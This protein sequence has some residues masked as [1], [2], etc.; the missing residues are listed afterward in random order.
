[1]LLALFKCVRMN[2]LS[3]NVWIS[4]CLA[5]SAN[6]S[7][8]PASIDPSSDTSKYSVIGPWSISAGFPQ[9]GSVW[10]SP[11]LG[12]RN[13]I[14]N[15]EFVSVGLNLASDKISKSESA[16]VFAKWSHMLSPGWGKSFPYA[17]V[18]SGYL[19]QKAN[20][21]A[22]NESSAN[23]A[24]GLGVE[25]SLLRELSTSVETGLGGVLWP[26]SQMS[27]TAATTQLA[28]HYHFQF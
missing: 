25:V 27:Y 24:F 8:G 17:F 16:G 15:G 11:A 7:A 5:A 2:P 18:Q 19:S 12:L 1:M 10:G 6:A 4:L 9:G 3:R 22:K 23:F 21:T 13:E 26:S 14:F 28:L 20:E